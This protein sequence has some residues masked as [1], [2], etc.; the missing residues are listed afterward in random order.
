MVDKRDIIAHCPLP[1]SKTVSLIQGDF[2]VC[3]ALLSTPCLGQNGLSLFAYNVVNP[4]FDAPPP[5]LH[6]QPTT[7]GQGIFGAMGR[8]G[9][10]HFPS[11]EVPS[12]R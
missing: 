1:P 12:L 10:T 8:K 11:N 3:P 7:T 2:A 5:H 6:S 9:S 4:V